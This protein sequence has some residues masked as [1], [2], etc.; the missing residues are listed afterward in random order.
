M[1]DKMRNLKIFGMKWPWPN[2]VIIPEFEPEHLRNMTH[3]TARRCIRKV[4]TLQINTWFRS[5][6]MGYRYWHLTSIFATSFKHLLSTQTV[7]WGTCTC[8]KFEY[9]WGEKDCLVT[10]RSINIIYWTPDTLLLPR[11]PPHEHKRVPAWSRYSQY[12]K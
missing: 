6:V 4:S 1:S 5:S 3:E 10:Y 9:K 2:R 7:R 8:W 12:Q 11:P